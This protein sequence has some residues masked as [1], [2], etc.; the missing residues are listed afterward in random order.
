MS[1]LLFFFV[2]LFLLVPFIL[3]FVLLV[4][5]LLFLAFLLLLFL[6]PL[7]SGPRTFAAVAVAI[8]IAVVLTVLGGPL[9][10]TRCLHLVRS[11]SL[12]RTSFVL[13]LQEAL[14]ALLLLSPNPDALFH[15]R[16]VYIQ[17]L[18]VEDQVGSR[19]DGRRPPLSAVC[20]IGGDEHTLTRTLRHGADS[21]LPAFDD[22]A[23]ANCERHREAVL[24][25]TV[26]L[27]SDFPTRCD[28][29]SGVVH[30]DLVTALGRAWA[31][32]LCERFQHGDRHN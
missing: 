23:H 9:A 30:H 25:R 3:P 7:A 18:N 16:L 26:K 22:L 10:N 14:R 21:L 13:H 8:A 31:R 24:T 20:Q 15:K 1:L 27:L 17:Q 32:A 6:A 11:L 12:C 19:R 5:L 28:Q 29:P 4:L 2:F